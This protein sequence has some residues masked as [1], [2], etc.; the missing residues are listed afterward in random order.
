MVYQM[1]D[2]GRAYFSKYF[3]HDYIKCIKNDSNG[4]KLVGAE[5][6]TR[7]GFN[8]LN[9]L[10]V[11]NIEKLYIVDVV[12]CRCDKI[13]KNDRVE[14]VLMDSVEAS[15]LFDDGYFDFV[16]L[17]TNPKTVDYANKQIDSWYPKSNKYFGGE[18]FSGNELTTVRAVLKLIDDNNLE[19]NWTG[20]FDWWVC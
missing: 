20:G 10:S 6:G 5:V 13:K 18:D 16:Y 15:E 1:G 2:F 11:L 7:E 3:I 19:L 4:K 14:F 12:D 17:D 9:M 8:A